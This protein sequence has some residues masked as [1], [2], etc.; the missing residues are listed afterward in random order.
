LY[1]QLQTAGLELVDCSV[2]GDRKGLS[3]GLRMERIKTRD[4]IQF[5]VHMEQMQS[6][7]VPLLDA[8]ADIRG[9]TIPNLYSI[10]V[11]AVFFVCYGL[12]WLLGYADVFAPFVSHVLG[13][14]V[15]FAVTA[16][17]FALGIMGA[18]DSKLSSAYGFW[19]GLQ[20]LF[21]FLVYTSLAGGFIALL[22]LLF[23]K[24]KPFKSAS[25]DSWVGRV[26]AGESKVPYGVA[27][28]IGALASFLFL[29]YASESV[30]RSFL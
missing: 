30:L 17:L 19:M 24:A 6:A 23:Q 9:M 27:I 8:L 29:G 12:L 14:L 28:V 2:I 4:L 3:L 7:G 15:V 11:A 18:A 16:P 13:G 21:P 26:Q 5:F 25:K 1:K 22:A 10:I 20:G